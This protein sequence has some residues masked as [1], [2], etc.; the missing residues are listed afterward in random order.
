MTRTPRLGLPEHPTPLMPG[1]GP[2][3][4]HMMD[5]AAALARPAWNKTLCE[6]AIRSAEFFIEKA[7][8]ALE[9]AK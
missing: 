7:K 5:A 2:V 4:M 1:I 8:A 9:Q 3:N 6:D